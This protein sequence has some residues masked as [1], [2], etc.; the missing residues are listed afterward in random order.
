MRNTISIGMRLFGETQS[1]AMRAYAQSRQYHTIVV[2]GDSNTIESS[3]DICPK[4]TI[5]YHCGES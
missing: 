3:I 4:W 2:S 1:K 5:S